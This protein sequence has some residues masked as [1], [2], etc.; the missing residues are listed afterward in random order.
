MGPILNVNQNQPSSCKNV[1]VNLGY[2]TISHHFKTHEFFFFFPLLYWISPEVSALVLATPL[3]ES[4]ELVKKL[5]RE[6]QD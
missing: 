3:Q 6:K 5:S 4:C 1:Y 2:T